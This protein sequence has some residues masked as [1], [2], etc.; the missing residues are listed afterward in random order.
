MSSTLTS[1]GLGSLTLTSMVY[2]LVAPLSAVTTILKELLPEWT[3]NS[4]VPLTLALLSLGEAF[5]LIFV[6]SLSNSTL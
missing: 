4:P 3:S 6:T 2:V 5:I 1:M